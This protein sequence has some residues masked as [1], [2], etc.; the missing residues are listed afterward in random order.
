MTA[1]GVS[2]GWGATRRSGEDR[3]EWNRWSVPDQ[4]PPLSMAF[5]GDIGIVPPETR[6]SGVAA[7]AAGLGY[8]TN[9]RQWRRPQYA[10]PV[11]T[12]PADTR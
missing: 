10:R 7:D 2:V 1:E 3:F 8:L 12:R 5:L 6:G 9:S 11:Q 4:P